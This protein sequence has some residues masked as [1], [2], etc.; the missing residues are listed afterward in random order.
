MPSDREEYATVNGV[1]LWTAVQGS[2][3]PLVLCH[4]GPGV[5]DYLGPIADMVNDVATVYRYDQR[6]CGR[7]KDLPPCDVSTFVDDLDGLRAHWG[8]D[9]W[10][11]GGHSWGANL[12]LA[13][14]LAYPDRA[15]GLVQLSG[16]GIDL[17]WRVEYHAN[18]EA[19][20]SP[21]ERDRFRYL[22]ERRKIAAGAE[23]AAVREER[24][25]LLELTEY[26]DVAQLESIPSYDE[27]PFNFGQNSE[28]NRDWERFTRQPDLASQ[29]ARLE[30][31][32]LIIYGEADPRPRRPSLELAE[33]LPHGRFV[34]LPEAGHDLWVQQPDALREAL[35]GFLQDIKGR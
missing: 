8:L 28:M 14:C 22:Q 2:G 16:T 13:Y 1:R 26:H 34:E 5:Y 11:V 21:E 4:G 27:F 19:R 31:P 33:L 17:H 35:R 25:R 30:T 10:L 12:A 24:S 6:G 3:P 15:I 23:L 9:T 20:L 32:A 29:V 18:R 7:S